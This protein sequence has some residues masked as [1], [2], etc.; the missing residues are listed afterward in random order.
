MKLL[1]KNHE[2]LENQIFLN[3][4]TNF[5]LPVVITNK[6]GFVEFVNSNFCSKS[7]F[8]SSFVIGQKPAIWRTDAHTKT[9]YENMWM[10]ILEGKVWNG[11]VRNKRFHRGTYDTHMTIIPI[12][13]SSG[14]KHFVAIHQPMD[15]NY[16]ALKNLHRL[17]KKSRI[18][19]NHWI[20]NTIP[21]GYPFAAGQ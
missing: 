5:N 3:F 9:F 12:E 17:Y 4:L 7:G 1:E 11:D 19:I 15:R 20:G 16:V 6:N 18:G 21:V 14:I 8:S 10:D 13:E 2:L